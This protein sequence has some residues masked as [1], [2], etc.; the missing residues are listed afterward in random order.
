M[1]GPIQEQFEKTIKLLKEKKARYAL[2]GGYASSL[3]RETDRF[4]KDIDFIIGTEGNVIEDSKEIIEALGLEAHKVREAQ[5]KGGPR[6]KVRSQSTPV[7]I[8]AG[9]SK[10]KSNVPVDFLLHLFPWMP[11]AL[12]RAQNNQVDIGFGW[13]IPVIT[14]EDLLLAKFMSLSDK[15]NRLDDLSDIKEIFAHTEID[16]PYLIGRMKKHDISSPKEADKLVPDIV[17]K[18]S[19]EI[20]LKQRKR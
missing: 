9:R 3:Y 1:M 8:V 20:R 12:D 18:T 11:E 15:A 17:R 6:H 7:W 10:S 4:T 19:N 14:P 2:V 13:E 16:L 5:L